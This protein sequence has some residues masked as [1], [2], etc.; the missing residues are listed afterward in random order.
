[1]GRRQEAYYVTEAGLY[2][3]IFRS[4]KP[5]AEKF[6]RW[7]FTEVPATWR[8]TFK[9]EWFE[10]I[11][12]V[13][14]LDYVKAKTP[15]FIGKVINEFVYEALIS[16]LPAELKARL[17]VRFSFSPHCVHRVCGFCLTSHNGAQGGTRT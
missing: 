9:D 15:G 11:L 16:G 10:A 6:R 8:R 14:G 13:W 4:D 17:Q 7:V 3:L 12:G 5:Q 2:R 1:M